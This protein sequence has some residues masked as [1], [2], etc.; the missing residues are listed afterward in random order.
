MTSRERDDLVASSLELGRL[1]QHHGTEAA[2][3]IPP[4]R[5][6]GNSHVGRQDS[7]ARRW[8]TIR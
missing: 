3:P 5:D 4:V 6:H 8:T 2:T 7:R 1:V